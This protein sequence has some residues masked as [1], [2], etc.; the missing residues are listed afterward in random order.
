[1]TRKNKLFL[2]LWAPLLMLALLTAGCG[3]EEVRTYKEKKTPPPAAKKQKGHHH[4]SM[5]SGMGMTTNTGAQK[6]N[7]AQSHFEWTTPE[8][9]TEKQT[10]SSFRLATFAVKNGAKG[11]SICTIIPLSGEAGGLKAN[12]SRWISQILPKAGPE[13]EKNLESVLAK[14]EKFL[15]SEKFAAV[16]VDLTTITPGDTD[17]STLATAITIKG[18]TIFIKMVGEKAHLLKNKEKF[19][20]LSKSFD[21]KAH[22]AEK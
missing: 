6:G 10:T 18:N 3:D 8:G 9:W 13:T 17:K 20:Q 11:E 5:G 21:T 19:T 2:L 15:A 4:G 16:L 12:V 7:A 22:K 14:Q 1:M